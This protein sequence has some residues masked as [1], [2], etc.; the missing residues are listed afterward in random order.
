MLGRYH[1]PLSFVLV[2]HQLRH[3]YGIQLNATI[4][5][6][7]RIINQEIQLDVS[8][9]LKSPPAFHHGACPGTTAAKHILQNLPP[10]DTRANLKSGRLASH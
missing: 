2:L 3:S 9:F 1:H 8:R 5:P 4:Q 6:R 10:H 7:F